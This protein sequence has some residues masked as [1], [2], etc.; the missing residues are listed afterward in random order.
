MRQKDNFWT[1]YINIMDYKMAS[2]QIY[3]HNLSLNLTDPF[4]KNC[5]II[6]FS[7]Q[8]MS[9]GSY[10]KSH[11]YIDTNYNFCH[12]EQI[13]VVA[14]HIFLCSTKTFANVKLL[15]TAWIFQDWWSFSNKEKNKD[16]V[17]YVSKVP[18]K[19]TSNSFV[20]LRWS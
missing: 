10:L 13:L 5:L 3:D 9:H 11:G 18:I 8:L 20:E 7:S 17:C 14:Q 15:R 1:T 2:C 12:K 16:R 6:T 19:P 4:L